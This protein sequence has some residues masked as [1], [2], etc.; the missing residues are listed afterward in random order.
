MARAK[1]GSKA[2]QRRKK[3][4]NLAEGY[5]GGRHR[6]FRTAKEAVDRGLVYAYRDRKNNKRNFRQ[7]WQIRIGAAVRELGLSYNRFMNGLKAKSIGLNRKMLADLA[8]TQP[9]DFAKLVETV[10]S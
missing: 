10:R 1:R 9:N 2:R 4:L 7:L 3:V 5:Y 6:L 8:V